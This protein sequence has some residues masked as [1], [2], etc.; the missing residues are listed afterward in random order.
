MNAGLDEL[1]A[2]IKI[3]WR[4]V[5]SLRYEDDTTLMAE[6]KEYIK[7]SLISVKEESEKVGLKLNIKKQQQQKMKIM[8]SSLVTSWQIN[9]GTWKQWQTSSSWGLK[10][11]WLVMATMKLDDYF[12][13]GKLWQT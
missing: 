2:W 11:L 9:R 7:N 1:Q 8:V 13:T 3:A 4:N 10:S 6:N 5:N 12:L